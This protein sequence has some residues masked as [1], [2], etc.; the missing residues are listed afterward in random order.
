MRSKNTYCPPAS[1][2]IAAI[3]ELTSA[4]NSVMT[5]AISHTANSISGEPIWLAMTPGLRKMPEPITAPTTNMVV[6]KK[7][8]DARSPTLARWTSA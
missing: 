4:P 1:G 3:S 5:P 6:E 2:I 8:S 7:P